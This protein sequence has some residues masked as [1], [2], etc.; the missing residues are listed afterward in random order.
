MTRQAT[1]RPLGV[2]LA[3]AMA[4]CATKSKAPSVGPATDSLHGYVGQQRILRFQGDQERVVVRKDDRPSMPGACDAAVEVRSAALEKG[5]PRLVLETLGAASAE[6]AR[7]R[8]QR[9]PATI[10]LSLAGFGGDSPA[11]LGRLDQILP[12]PEAYLRAYGIPFERAAG[13]EPSLAASSV[14]QVDATDQERR[15]E[16]RLTARPRKLFWVDPIHRDPRRA[17]RHEGE[18]ELEG[19]VG[20][21]GRLYRTR[22]RGSLDK[23]HVSAIE[24]VLPMWRFEPARTGNDPT[25]AHVLARLVLRIH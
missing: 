11:M 2:A 22:V 15:L 14:N 24:R 16:L 7:P 18:V 10:T 17:A 20:V 23:A 9:I 4:A 3:L 1:A 25:P 6:T 19:V 12:S 21:D 8:C 5:A 13:S